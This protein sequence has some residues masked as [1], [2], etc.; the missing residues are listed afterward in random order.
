MSLTKKHKLDFYEKPI[1]TFGQVPHN[2]FRIFKRVATRRA[3]LQMEFAT[4][5][6]IRG[7][8]THSIRG[9][10]LYPVELTAKSGRYRDVSNGLIGI[11]IKSDGAHVL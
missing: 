6:D 10:R 1:M 5:K 8:N 7:N 2:H 9:G 4:L 3:K 11:L